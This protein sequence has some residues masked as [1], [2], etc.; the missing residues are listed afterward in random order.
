[1]SSTRVIAG[2]SSSCHL[3]PYLMSMC[4]SAGLCPT[5]KILSDVVLLTGGGWVLKN[6]F[7]CWWD[8]DVATLKAKSC[9]VG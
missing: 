9:P 1:M 7:Y 2:L 6:G 8:L 5:V 4:G 3:Y